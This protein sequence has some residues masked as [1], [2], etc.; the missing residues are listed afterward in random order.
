MYNDIGFL[1]FQLIFSTENKCRKYLFK[2]RWPKGFICPRCEYTRYSYH[3]TK[4]LYQCSRCR[5][6]V[7]LTAGTIFHKT[8][9][10][11]RKWFWMIYLISQSKT[12]ISILTLQRLLEISTYRT[13][14]MMSHK[15]R[16]AMADRDSR[17][18]LSGLVEMDDSFYGTKHAKGKRGRGA[19]KKS[20]VIV[21]VQ[22]KDDHAEFTSLKVVNAIS[23]EN[24]NDLAEENINKGST[25]TTDGYPSYRSLKK[26]GY[27]HIQKILYAPEDASKFLPWVHIMISNSKSVIRG[28]HHGVS[29]KHIQRYLDSF[30][31]LFNRRYWMDQIFDRLLTA[32]FSTF[33]ITLAELRA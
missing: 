13:A 11:L 23:K 22:V 4:L 20:S 26:K 29:K 16:K 1:K 14:W 18:T 5:Y 3:G 17:Y 21:S 8:R 12:G 19:D 25:I 24:V 10:P 31:Y 32:C 15:I 28:T 6:Q 30:S 27:H 2:K 7:S 33:T 9:T